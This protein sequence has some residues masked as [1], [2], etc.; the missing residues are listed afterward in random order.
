MYVDSHAHVNFGMY[1]NVD[2]VLKEASK[3]NVQKLL[4]VLKI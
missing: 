4:I 2:D 1:E 3:C